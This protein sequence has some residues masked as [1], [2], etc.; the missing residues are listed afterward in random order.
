MEVFVKAVRDDNS[1]SLRLM[2][3]TAVR[4]TVFQG[5]N[6]ELP[7]NLMGN[8]IRPSQK[9]PDRLVKVNLIKV[10]TSI[11]AKMSPECVIYDENIQLLKEL[12]YSDD[13]KSAEYG[14]SAI[15]Q[16]TLIPADP[17]GTSDATK[18]TRIAC[19]PQLLYWMRLRPFHKKAV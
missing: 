7:S 5:A 18:R 9:E 12:L 8:I 10:D 4:L 3:A 19:C 6:A 14:I 15:Y 2:A 17:K 1:Q 16:Q 11:A 13:M